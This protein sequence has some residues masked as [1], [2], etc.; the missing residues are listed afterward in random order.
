PTTMAACVQPTGFVDASTDCDDSNASVSP[1]GSE[2]CDGLDND[3][4]GLLDLEDPSNNGVAT[5]YVDSDGDGFG[6]TAETQG[7]CSAP[8]GYVGNADDCDDANK[9]VNPDGIEICDEADNNCNGLVDDEDPALSEAPTWYE[10]QDG[11]GSGD[12]GSSVV[13]C[14]APEGFVDNAT[15][16]NDGDENIHP[17][18]PEVCGGSDE[19]C[20]GLVDDEDPT[21]EG[22]SAQTWYGDE[23]G[24]GHGS[25]SKTSLACVA[26]EGSVEEGQDCDDSDPTVYS[27]APELDDGKD[28]NCDGLVDGEKADGSCGGCSAST[29]G[30]QALWLALLPALVLRRRRKA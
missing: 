24:D 21:L 8:E 11:D 22:S 5:W 19:N 9:L 30:T 25:E 4:D 7:A 20:D 2:I 13:T 23:D 12:E 26:P 15:D 29:D 14:D 27:G 16:C 1:D 28:N 10:D 3:C 18:V 6:S 17:G